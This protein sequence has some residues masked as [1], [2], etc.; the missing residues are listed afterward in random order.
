MQITNKNHK[1]PDLHIYY[2]LRP[3][4][5]S[6]DTC[7]VI[8]IEELK[9]WIFSKIFLS[10]L[11]RYKEALLFSDELYFIPRPFV[12]G[13]VLWLMSS[14]SYFVSSKQRLPVH[15]LFIL[16]QLFNIPWNFFK[17][18]SLLQK[19]S[20]KIEALSSAQKQIKENT[21]SPFYLRTN[22]SFGLKS[23]G[24][25][26]HTS[27]VL[28]NLYEKYKDI[29]FYT[30]D[31]TPGI[32]AQI[33]SVTIPPNPN[34]LNFQEIPNFAYNDQFYETIMA[35]M[36]INKPSFIYQR[37]SVESYVGVQLAHELSAPL[38]LEFNGSEYWISKH[39]GKRLKYEELAIKIENLCLLKA[40]LIVVVSAPLKKDLL[41][42]GIPEKRILVNPNGVD[43]ELYSPDISGQTV[44]QKYRLESKFVF[45]FIG[46]FGQWHGVNKLVESFAKLLKEHPELQ[47]S[48]RLLLIGDGILRKEVEDQIKSYSIEPFCIL[49]GSVRQE[50]GPGHLAACDILMSPHVS[51]DDS[52]EF[53]GSPTKIF[54]YMAMGKPIISSK[55][56]QL[57][58]ILAH[59]KT[60]FLVEPGDVEALKDAMFFLL[61]EKDLCVK[62]GQAARTEILQKHTWKAHTEKTLATLQDL[63]SSGKI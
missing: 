35:E 63:L 22:L 51:N 61:H 27:G 31:R 24:M 16:S 57:A 5:K 49:T 13:L 33:K 12:I 15:F 25:V 50:E 28:N 11:F 46:T 32:H 55:L 43:P 44:R 8:S 6:T 36:T 56:G 58:E 18:K 48:C 10:K 60:A 41:K 37:Y 52:T 39:W 30:S 40:D 4:L 62:L 7:H 20:R 2:E 17:V 14:K 21:G 47:S 1:K 45:G 59:N 53:F 42:L 23:G 34:F 9:E 38:V 3:N 54:E 29:R 19:T 26:T